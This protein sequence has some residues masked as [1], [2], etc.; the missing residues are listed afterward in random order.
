[1][2][3]L[4]E[5]IVLH[6]VG[7]RDGL[8]NESEPIPTDVKIAFLEALAD[9]GHT[10]I[11]V[12]SFVSPKWVPQLADAREVFAGITRRDGVT[13]S[14]LVPN[15]R[16]LD[17]ALECGVDKVAIFL[18]ASDTFSKKNINCTV[19]E[20]FERTK[21]VVERARAEGL[22]V[23]GYMS[24]AFYCPYEGLVA[25]ERTAELTR[26]LVEIG[27]EELSI[28]DTIG[29]ARPDDIDRVLDLIQTIVAPEALALHLHDTRGM[30]VANIHHALRR[31]V[32]AFDASAGGLGGC[33]YAKGASGNV[34]TEDVLWLLDGLGVATGVDLAGVVRAS[35]LI[36]S[37]LGRSLPGRA[38]QGMKTGILNEE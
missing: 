1:M 34:A 7:A 16:G 18:A 19:D 32:V 12:S 4:P 14:A 26:R 5:R 36:E 38:Y 24:T 6:E 29:H 28:G 21:P 3:A 31:G 35:R 17:R 23:R 8:Q 25:A 27:C 10:E 22:R 20:S 37:A 2:S 13:Y 11:E 9:A 30:A 33:P 15:D